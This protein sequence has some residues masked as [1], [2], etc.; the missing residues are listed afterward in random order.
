MAWAARVMPMPCTKESEA[1]GSV[2]R[3]F[4]SQ[5]LYCLKDQVEAKHAW[6]EVGESP[7]SRIQGQSPP[8]S[9]VAPATIRSA[10]TLFAEAKVLK[11]DKQADREGVVDVSGINVGD[12]WRQPSASARA[13][14]FPLAYW[15]DPA[16]Q[17]C[18]GG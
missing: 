9:D 15:S 10:L 11:Q 3:C 4:T 6:V 17:V 13:E 7:A 18:C 5:L 1:S 14:Q 12:D 16:C 2:V 8:G